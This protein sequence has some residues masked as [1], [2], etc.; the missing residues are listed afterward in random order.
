MEEGKKMT[1]PFCGQVY[2]GL[3]AC[4]VGH[5]YA[6]TLFPNEKP[7]EETQV[8]APD[9]TVYR[10]APAKTKPMFG[11]CDMCGVMKTSVFL[12]PVTVE[13]TP[14]AAAFFGSSVKTIKVCP[15]CLEKA[16][17][18]PWGKSAKKKARKILKKHY[19]IK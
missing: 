7:I 5:G 11:C 14:E 3:H 8:E 12:Q 4:P 13:L 15:E 6:G 9:G 19:N 17:D 1:C 16:Y 10:E 2:E 18:I